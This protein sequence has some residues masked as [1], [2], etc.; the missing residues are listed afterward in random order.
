M[1]K[2]L[3][4]ETQLVQWLRS[5]RPHAASHR[6]QVIMGPP[7][8]HN[9]D[10]EILPLPISSSTFEEIKLRWNFPSEL[11]RIML[12]TMPLATEFET[13]SNIGLMLRSAWS[14]D[15][16]FSLALTYNRKMGNVSGLIHGLQEHEA[17]TLLSSLYKS[18]DVVEDPLLFPLILF[19]TK[20]HLFILCT[21][22]RESS[23]RTQESEAQ[24]A[25]KPQQLSFSDITQKLTGIAGTLAFCEMTFES[26]LQGLSVARAWRNKPINHSSA[27]VTECRWNA[28][29]N[30]DR[31]NILAKAHGRVLE[32]RRAAHV[33]T[34]YSLIGQRDNRLNHNMAKDSH[35]IAEIS[36]QDNATMKT[37]SLLAQRDSS[38]MRIIAWAILIF[39]PGTFTAALFSSTF[40]DFL[41]DD[42]PRIVSWW[43]WLY[44]L[45]T[46]FVTGLVLLGWYHFSRQSRFKIQ[47][48]LTSSDD[49]AKFGTRST[50]IPN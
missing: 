32:A 28:C 38:D 3:V 39:L 37:M 50:S 24:T 43:I 16:S 44:C 45:V 29:T 13:D 42:N 21:P 41:P 20:I 27:S 8:E 10:T 17:Q 12:S 48:D 23:Q 31:R 47:E 25:E 22:P 15:C 49:L 30:I 9:N 19:E 40:F 26:C 36:Y 33:Q 14:R 34:V 1:L 5:S 6:L 18:I 46:L 11:L 2:T 4:D 7:E 35:R